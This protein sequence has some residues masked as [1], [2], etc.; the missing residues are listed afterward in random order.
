VNPDRYVVRAGACRVNVRIVDK[1]P[2]AAGD[3]PIV[4]PRAFVVRVGKPV[5]KQ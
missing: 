2:A 3:Q 4:G 1:K 5:C